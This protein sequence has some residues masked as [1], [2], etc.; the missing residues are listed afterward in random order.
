MPGEMSNKSDKTHLKPKT[1]PGGAVF[2]TTIRHDA[3]HLFLYVEV[4]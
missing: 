3:K 2:V 1:A 4:T